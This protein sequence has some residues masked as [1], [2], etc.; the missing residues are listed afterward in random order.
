M[1]VRALV[2]TRRAKSAHPGL[3]RSAHVVGAIS[4]ETAVVAEE[5]GAVAMRPVA[6]EGLVGVAP[7]LGVGVAAEIWA[8]ESLARP[9]PFALSLGGDWSGSHPRGAVVWA[10]VQLGVA[11]G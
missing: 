11:G 3:L 5:V 1:L 9:R 4:A 10:P 2:W 7:P 6:V 8:V